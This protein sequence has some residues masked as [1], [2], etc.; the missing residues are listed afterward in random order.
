MPQIRR[1]RRAEV[2]ARDR[3]F[4]ADAALERAR[5]EFEVARVE[6]ERRYDEAVAE[7]R[8]AFGR[9]VE[10]WV[11]AAYLAKIRADAAARSAELRSEINW[12]KAQCQSAAEDAEILSGVGCPDRLV[13]RV[14]R[15]HY[16]TQGDAWGYARRDA[17]MKAARLARLGVVAKVVSTPGSEAYEVRACLATSED[18][19]LCKLKW[20]GTTV[21]QCAVEA[22]RRGSHPAVHWPSLAGCYA[23]LDRTLGE[24]RR[25]GAI[26]AP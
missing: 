14:G 7:L 22:W 18:V 8:A 12:R 4:H 26:R 19:E 3:F 20:D 2:T 15:Y 25:L 10:P 6:F 23:L 16:S 5:G 9:N 11:S 24:A 1:R 21:E 17:E 13:W